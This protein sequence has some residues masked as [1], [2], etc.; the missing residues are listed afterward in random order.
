MAMDLSSA[1]WLARVTRDEGPIYL[2]LAQ[3]LEAAIRSGELQPGE[4]LPP[5]RAVARRLGVDFTTV[6]RAYG[7]ARDRGL[8]EG[9]T[10]RGTFVRARAAD[11]EAG[12]VDLSMNL[13]A[14]PLG[15]SLAG[16][17][18]ETTRAILQRSDAATLMAYHPG[19]GA[20]G[21]KAA[22]AAWLAP[23]LGEV[24][25]ERLLVSPGAQTALAAVLA[26]ICK[27]GDA[28]VAEP[29]SY[30]GFKAAAAH[31]GLRLIPCPV[32][33]EGVRPEALER[34]CRQARP[35]AIYLVPTMQNPTASTMGAERRREV[36]TLAAAHDLWV[37]EDDPYSRLMADPPPAVA[38]FAPERT[39]HV[40]TLAKCLTPGLRIAFVACPDAATT[41]RIGA[42]LRAISLMPAPLMAA[43]ATAWIR[44]GT[45]QALLAGVRQEAQARRALAAQA[46]PQALGPAE[47][48]HVWLPL[49]ESLSPDRLRL[50]A[51]ERGLSLV[52]A[53]AF[54]TGPTWPS[55]V[56]I[57][58]GGPAKRAVLSAAL[59]SIA[60]LAGG[61]PPRSRLVV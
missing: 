58:L 31:L 47:S 40:A 24:R 35:A 42:S 45:A 19:A 41:E 18:G 17:L 46:L 38:S 36:A 13:P 56:R 29:L 51:Q 34:L 26:A 37:I 32:D 3:A 22:A 5:Q 39:F 30:P 14:P 2:S 52:T 44:D 33:A 53:E 57:S 21:Q 6:T 48:L 1:A 7:V 54:A 43:V 59:A 25:P 55:G 27:P 61:A 16:L 60:E 9:T 4:Q 28:V 49:P 50:S 23:G 20:P 12:L 10:G 8:V 11:D 15:V